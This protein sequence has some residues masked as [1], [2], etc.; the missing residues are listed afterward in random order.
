M[1]RM[2]DYLGSQQVVS[3][4]RKWL[5][6]LSLG[7]HHLVDFCFPN[8]A[9]HPFLTHEKYIVRAD[10]MLSGRRRPIRF[11][12]SHKDSW[13]LVADG[14]YCEDHNK[15]IVC[16]PP[17]TVLYPCLVTSVDRAILI[18]C[19]VHCHL[20]AYAQTPKHVALMLDFRLDV[21]RPRPAPSSSFDTETSP[22]SVRERSLGMLRRAP[23]G[24]FALPVRCR[25]GCCKDRG[26]L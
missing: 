5:A 13:R 14:E 1:S 24:M 7:A 2:F 11:A 4:K 8:A 3:V 6:S 9:S 21:N 26:P 25:N 19:V 22:S 20:S 16:D 12:K 10:N 18:A 15:S 17:H 23:K